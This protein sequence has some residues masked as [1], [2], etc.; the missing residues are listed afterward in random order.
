VTASSTASRL[1]DGIRERRRAAGLTQRQLAAA[2]GVGVGI[3]RDMEQGVTR[4]PH[5]QSL[6]LL[7]M[8]LGMESGEAAELIEA[9][10]QVL[11]ER[12]AAGA[13]AGTSRAQ[14]WPAPRGSSPDRR[15]SESMWCGILGPLEVL[16]P[17][18]AVRPG[19]PRHQAVLGLLATSPNAVVERRSIIDALWPEE[20]PPSAVTMIHSYI[21]QLRKLL[22]AGH[23]GTGLVTV[24]S[25]YRLNVRGDELDLLVF[26]RRS[27]LAAQARDAGD[28]AAAFGL[29]GEALALWRGEPLADIELLYGHPVITGLRAQRATAVVDYAETARSRREHEKAIP[30]LRA[31]AVREPLNERA[32]ACLMTAL[33]QSGQ[34]AAA[35]EVFG[36]IRRRLDEQLGVAPA[37]ELTAAHLRVLR[38]SQR[39]AQPAGWQEPPAEVSQAPSP[40][41]LPAAIP[42]FTGR[43][44]ELSQL[45]RVISGGSSVE[46]PLALITGLPGAGKTTLA[47]RAAH[48]LRS[49]FP[50]GQLWVQ[51]DGASERPR[52]PAGLLG[53]LLRSLGVPGAA[54][55]DTLAEKAAMYRSRLADRKVLL[56]IDDAATAGQVLP[57]IPGTAGSAVIVTS[58][59]QLGE[60]HG[61]RVMAL[62][63]L[64]HEEAVDLLG[65]IVGRQR[66]RADQQAAERLVR[67]CG[68]LPL[69]VRIAGAR[70]ARRPSWPV[71]LM[72]DALADQQRRLDELESGSLSVR[73]SFAMSYQALDPAAQR[74]LCFLSTLGPTDV[75][76]WAIAAMLGVAD[77]GDVVNRLTDSSLLTAV[78]SDATGTARY[79]L[80]DLV[81]DFAVERLA[82]DHER[83]R[84]AAQRRVALA[85]LQLAAAADARLPSEPYFPP[86][87][88]AEAAGELPAEV[89]G[90]LTAEPVAWFSAERRNLLG[91]VE[92]SC[93]AG[94]HQLAAALAARMA[95]YQHVTRR[96]DDAHDVWRAVVQAARQAADPA[97]AAHAELRAAAVMCGQG[98]HAEALPVVERCSAAFGELGDGRAIAAALYWKAV[99]Q[100]NLGAIR[101][102]MA[103][104]TSALRLARRIGDRQAELLA[105]RIIAITQAQLPGF[106]AAANDSCAQALAVAR[107]L[108][109]PA[110]EYEILH[111][112][113]HVANLTGRPH[114][115]IDT[116]HQA[117]EFRKKLGVTLD[118]GSWLGIRGDAEQGLGRYDQAAQAYLTALP[119]FRRQFMGRHQALCLLKLSDCY[120][121]MGQ[122]SQAM[123]SAEESLPIFRE[124]RLA[125]YA[126]RATRTIGE[127]E[128]ALPAK[129]RARH[130]QPR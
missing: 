66:V 60:L 109:Q 99:C 8:A 2:A 126:D 100:S 25:G 80:H 33:A 13:S 112:V 120:R 128:R 55:P 91:V 104:G 82:S 85:W 24:G 38:G 103:T 92:R 93:Q 83:E 45:A 116:Y 65:R 43:T 76:E 118:E 6:L 9:G 115:A 19:G 117:L 94:E 119:I 106:R 21:A 123:D 52:Q 18:G 50:D 129:A 40:C 98:R 20:P 64:G 72:S 56:V 74:A 7:A 73:A 90:R 57:L 59:M 36:E 37:A 4:Q 47:L 34:Q 35:L 108:G 110:W 102:G 69:A 48:E 70:L 11:A 121:A 124:L 10:T 77:A 31:L 79:R 15:E 101:D 51:L 16:G 113:G 88:D 130:E 63:L 41:Q 42:N 28:L 27:L 30:H 125:H 105:L 14:R 75:A 5:R 81:R 17:R 97:A 32:H 26:A 107:D 71:S 67:A 54:I 23:P 46:V 87:A 111:T 22:P 49:H 58:R 39:D 29:F 127:C 1:A 95:A 89:A 53:E 62:D 122:L 3:V 68:R 12:L 78:G 114:A 96:L 86:P 44:A 61:A 84:P